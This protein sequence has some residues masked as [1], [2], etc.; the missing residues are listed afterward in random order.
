MHTNVNIH[1][2]CSLFFYTNMT[3][4]IRELVFR[5]MGGM[6]RECSSGV[7]LA[8]VLNEYELVIDDRA[9]FVRFR[10]Y[11]RNVSIW[12]RAGAGKITIVVWKLE[13]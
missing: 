9:E 8:D 5:Q 12:Y 1:Q 13:K 6:W 11:Q 4:P 7:L 2:E 10:D 3:K